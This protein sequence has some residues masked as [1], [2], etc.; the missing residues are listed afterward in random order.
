MAT[1][2]E[3]L[4]QAVDEV[5]DPAWP[6]ERRRALRRWSYSTV[7]RVAAGLLALWAF[8]LIIGLTLPWTFYGFMGLMMT[9]AAFSQEEGREHLRRDDRMRRQ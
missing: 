1:S 4:G 9:S 2:E 6:D 8:G 7:G 5:L 3:H